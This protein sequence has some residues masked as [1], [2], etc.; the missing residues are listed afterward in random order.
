[1]IR[2]GALA[3]ILFSITAQAAIERTANVEQNANPVISGVAARANVRSLAL[4][5]IYKFSRNT[6][7]IPS[8]VL[9]KNGPEDNIAG[10]SIDVYKDEAVN[11]EFLDSGDV[12]MTLRLPENENG[13]VPEQMVLSAEEFENL[14][15]NFVEN[16]TVADL[17]ARYTGYMDTAVAGKSRI[18]ARKHSIR[19]ESSRRGSRSGFRRDRN[20]RIAGGGGN[21]V[22]V[23]KSLTGFSGTAGN[24]IGMAGALQRRGW[25][26][27][28][29]SG[30][31][32]G[33]VCSWSGG[34]HGKGHVGWFDGSCFQ[35]TY[36][37]NCGSP[38]RNYHLLKCV[39][40]A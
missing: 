3:L 13:K 37:G 38:G 40:P 27:I 6:E 12:L 14:G 2:I 9:T 34:F 35:P 39:S 22:S 1:M 36:G 8:T 4:N 18:K 23:V 25:K 20:G 15:L 26:S 29:Y 30:V 7:V 24:G 5:G 28:S 17:K 33:S 21:C 32:R 31:Q 10:A 19:V 11:V 16:G